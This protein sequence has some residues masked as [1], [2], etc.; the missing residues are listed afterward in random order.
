MTDLSPFVLGEPGSPRALSLQDNHQAE[1]RRASVPLGT[2]FREA[3]PPGRLLCRPTGH[4]QGVQLHSEEWGKGL[5]LL[6]S[7]HVTQKIL[8]EE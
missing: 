5:T 3:N 8:R 4:A 2:K 6:A 7:C 1:R